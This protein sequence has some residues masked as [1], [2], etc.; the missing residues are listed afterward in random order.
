MIIAFNSDWIN[1]SQF[2]KHAIGI[3]FNTAMMWI[4]FIL[5]AGTSKMKKQGNDV[6]VEVIYHR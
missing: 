4:S 3:I 1:I 5:T 6:D 2:A